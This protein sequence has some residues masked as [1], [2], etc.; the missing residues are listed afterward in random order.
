LTSP[1]TRRGFTFVELVIVITVIAALAGIGFPVYKSVKKNVDKNATKALVS[2]VVTAMSTYQLKT[3]TWN[4]STDPLKPEMHT[5]HMWD[6]NHVKGPD[7]PMLNNDTLR[8]YSIDGYTP[9]SRTEHDS[10]WREKIRDG[11]NLDV[12]RAIE[13]KWDNDPWFKQPDGTYDINFPKEVLAS[14]YSGFINMAAPAV[15]KKFI[16]KRGILV[17][18]WEQ[19][20]RIEFGAKKFGTDPMGIWSA[21]FD[22]WDST[23]T[24]SARL[25]VDDDTDDLR[26]WQ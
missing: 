10:D 17:D 8:F 20:L 2:A 24:D 26:S 25:Q 11:Q 7:I 23:F 19:P 12:Q 1:I 15:H 22:K 21:G 13:S 14:G 5:Y 9:G 3:W 6:L 16:N 4:V 18:A